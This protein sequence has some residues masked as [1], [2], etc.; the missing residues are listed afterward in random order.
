MLAPRFRLA[1]LDRRLCDREPLPMDSQLSTRRRTFPPASNFQLR[2]LSRCTPSGHRS[3][4][5]RPPTSTTAGHRSPVA[6]RRS[7]VTDHESPVA[8]KSF[9]MH[10]YRKCARKSCGFHCYEIIELKLPWNDIL[11]KNTGGG[12]PF[13]T[14][15]FQ[16][17]N[18]QLST[19]SP[20]VHIAAG[21]GRLVGAY[22]IGGVLTKEPANDQ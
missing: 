11:T 8:A 21:R 12:A 14:R 10:C 18:S 6:A 20:T 2:F 3:P 5:T 7:R 1:I 22:T 4:D 19:A 9:R 15:H 16:L 13:S 17:T